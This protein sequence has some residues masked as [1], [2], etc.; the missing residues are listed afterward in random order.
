MATTAVSIC[1][2]ALSRIG[3][4]KVIEDLEEDSTEA[5]VC[6][7]HYDAVRD[8]VLADFPWPFATRYATLALDEA[9]DDQEWAPEWGYSYRY[10]TDCLRVL[11][12]VAASNRRS[13]IPYAIGSDED[14]LLIFTDE[15]EP[16]IVYTHRN[17]DPTQYPPAFVSAFAW[18]LAEEI[19]MTL[20][21]SEALRARAEERY[22]RALT[23]AQANAFNE[24]RSDDNPADEFIQARS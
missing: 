24:E 9:A 2:I 1:N 20:A 23:Q 5:D 19:A 15:A 22:V 8:A 12:I 10:P 3:V 14:G 16:V 17:E 18:R 11:R 4:S 7:T 13:N 21:V 6:E